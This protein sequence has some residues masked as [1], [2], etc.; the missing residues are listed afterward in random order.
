MKEKILCPHCKQSFLKKHGKN[1]KG[2]IRYRCHECKKIHVPNYTSEWKL[3][4]SEKKIIDRAYAEKN[5]IRSIARII[6]RS[7]NTVFNYLKKKETC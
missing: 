7:Y 4:D 6:N 5:S 2:Y 1:K 3:T